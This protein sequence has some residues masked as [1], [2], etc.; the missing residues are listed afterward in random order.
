MAYWLILF[1]FL[2]LTP[3]TPSKN[4][5]LGKIDPATD[6]RFV[7][8]AAL[9]TAG[10]ARTQY[11]QRKTYEAFVKMAKA[12][13]KDGISLVIVSATRTFSMQ[14]GIWEGKWEKEKEISNPVD[15]AKK[16]LQYSSMP[17]TS[18]HHWGTD[19][20]LN[21]L[22]NAYFASGEGQKV[23]VWLQKNAGSFGFC[24]TYTSKTETGRTGYEE[25]KWHWSYMPLSRV[26][27]ETYLKTIKSTDLMGFTGEEVVSEIP[28]LAE[29]I[30]GIAC[31]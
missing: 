30:G 26:Y 13:K 2:G 14:K 15:R 5:L 9:Y 19:I 16:I 6:A 21:A 8:P 10:A 28:I 31:P 23:Y 18:R 1:T 24:Q 3:T 7:K 29:F 12:A 27:L 20:D 11:L 17:G 22:N 4:D 25:E